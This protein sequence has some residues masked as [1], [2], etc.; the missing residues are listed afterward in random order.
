MQKEPVY[1]LSIVN[2]Y[3]VHKAGSYMGVSAI[4]DIDE[5]TTFSLPSI[6]YK[7]RADHLS[8]QFWSDP[9][10]QT[11]VTIEVPYSVANVHVTDT[12]ADVAGAPVYVFNGSSAYLGIYGTTDTYGM[13][14]FDLPAGTYRFRAD[15]AAAN[16]GPM[17]YPS[18]PIRKTRWTCPWISWP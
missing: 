7:I 11:D 2:I 5:H 12:G 18:S 16:T 13:V 15:G 1:L 14:S 17:P 4:T 3:L 10:I 9:F 8:Q 6:S